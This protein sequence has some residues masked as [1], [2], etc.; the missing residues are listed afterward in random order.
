MEEND[1]IWRFIDGDCDEA[2]TKALLQRIEDDPEFKQAVEERRQLDEAFGSLELEQPSMRFTTNVME[3]LPMLYQQLPTQHLLG[4]AWVKAFWSGLTFLMLGTIGL[5]FFSPEAAT[6][7]SGS[8][9]PES[10]DISKLLFL[11]YKTAIILL[12]ISITSIFLVLLDKQL[13]KRRKKTA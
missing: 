13:S 7:S 2:E 4:P 1:L 5:G 3:H 8:F 12:S 6:T 11:P 10:I 9:S